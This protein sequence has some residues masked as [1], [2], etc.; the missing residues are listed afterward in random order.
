[1]PKILS[2]FSVP[3]LIPFFN[4]PDETSV[5]FSDFV[6]DIIY[7]LKKKDSLRIDNRFS[8]VEN[9]EIKKTI[10]T[11]DSEF[12]NR[13]KKDILPFIDSLKGDN[14][15]YYAIIGGISEEALLDLKKT[16]GVEMPYFMA[17]DILMF[18]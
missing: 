12:L 9:K 11:W 1:M 10:Y 13:M 6:Q 15:T 17:D 18:V 14:V 16:I 7:F 3:R 2:P 8:H 5:T 4:K